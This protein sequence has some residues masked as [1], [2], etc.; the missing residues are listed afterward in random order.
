MEAH[1]VSLFDLLAGLGLIVLIIAGV[2]ISYIVKPDSNG[3]RRT[4]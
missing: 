1:Q 2:V 4:K 3:S